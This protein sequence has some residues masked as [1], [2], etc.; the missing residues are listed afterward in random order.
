MKFIKYSYLLILL[1]ILNNCSYQR[2]NSIDQKKFSIKDINI[3]G[4][5]RSSY[6]ISKKINRFSNPKSNN[7]I[8]LDIVI[9]KN[10]EIAE[11]NIQNKVTKYKLVMTSKVQINNLNTGSQNE[12]KYKTERLYDVMDKYSATTRNAK[13]A[14][15]S[16]VNDIADQILDELKISFK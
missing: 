2:V 14:L 8:S 9:N 6:I 12:R 5:N 15:N 1:L 4:D 3:E 13:N 11:K 7:N 10:L 16:S